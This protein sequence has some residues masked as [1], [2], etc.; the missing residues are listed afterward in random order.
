M[1]G[2]M[3][4]ITALNIMVPTKVKFIDHKRVY[5]ETPLGDDFI[6]GFADETNY[7]IERQSVFKVTEVLAVL[8][9]KMYKGDSGVILGTLNI[10]LTNAGF[11]SILF[12]QKCESVE[13]TDE[14]VRIGQRIKELR[15]EK[16]IDA[17]SMAAAAGIDA[18]NLSRIESGKYSVGIDLLAKIANVC[19]KKLDFVDSN[20]END[21]CIFINNSK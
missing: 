17:K 10:E 5:V 6:V 20:D 11:C 8:F 2:S 1:S 3:Y 9:D 13:K 4:K 21:G 15:M 16:G 12:Y 18:S 14:R 19:G 7:Q